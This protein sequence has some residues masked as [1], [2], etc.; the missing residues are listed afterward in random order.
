M[1]AYEYATEGFCVFES[2]EL[3][4]RHAHILGLDHRLKLIKCRH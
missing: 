2:L 1:A 4:P 3:T